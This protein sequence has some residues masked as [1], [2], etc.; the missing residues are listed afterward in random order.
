MSDI[1]ILNWI[2]DSLP[3]K[4]AAFGGLDIFKPENEPPSNILEH[5][6]TWMQAYEVCGSTSYCLHVLII[7][8]GCKPLHS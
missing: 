6:E 4:V 2:I 1:D 3:T 8:V 7:L 5:Y